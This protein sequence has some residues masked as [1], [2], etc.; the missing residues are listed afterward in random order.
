M[1]AFDV[2]CARCYGDSDQI[3][4]TCIQQSH[5]SLQLATMCKSVRGYACGHCFRGCKKHILLRC[6]SFFCFFFFIFLL[7]KNQQRAILRIGKK[8]KECNCWYIYA[9]RRW[10]VI[11]TNNSNNTASTPSSC[12]N[13]TAPG[14]DTRSEAADAKERLDQVRR[15]SCSP[16]WHR[17]I[18]SLISPPQAVW[19]STTTS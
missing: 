13:R 5:M 19:H 1:A 7:R 14:E 16:V 4:K 9:G 8:K 11:I 15:D 12:R 6:I 17:G 3:N 18:S 10:W 2:Q